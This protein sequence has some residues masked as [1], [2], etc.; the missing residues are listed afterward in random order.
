M[1]NVIISI[2]QVRFYFSKVSCLTSEVIRWLFSRVNI[3][4]KKKVKAFL[5]QNY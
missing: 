1:R 5:F 4:F 2:I 3:F